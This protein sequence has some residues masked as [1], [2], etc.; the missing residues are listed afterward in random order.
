MTYRTLA[1]LVALMFAGLGSI[2]AT[3]VGERPANWEE[4]GRVIDE[5]ASRELYAPTRICFILFSFAFAVLLW[6]K[7]RRA[8]RGKAFEREANEFLFLMG[9]AAALGGIS[10]LTA[11]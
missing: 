10:I 5:R 7:R 9:F 1:L 8:M 4:L 2:N 3:D 6:V 11:P